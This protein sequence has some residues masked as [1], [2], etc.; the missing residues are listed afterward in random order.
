MRRILMNTIGMAVA[1]LVAATSM[2]KADVWWHVKDED[3]LLRWEYASLVL[4]TGC[5]NEMHSMQAIGRQSLCAAAG[6]AIG[7]AGGVII[8]SLLTP[9]EL[10]TTDSTMYYAIDHFNKAISGMVGTYIGL[11][12]GSFCGLRWAQQEAF[13]RVLHRFVIHWPEHRDNM[14]HELLATFDTLYRA[15]SHGS[16]DLIIEESGVALMHSVCSTIENNKALL[17]RKLQKS[18]NRSL[19]AMPA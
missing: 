3:A 18:L 6:S 17:E 19:R 9:S 4:V 5:D 13:K 16:L 8:G 1:I 2:L 7:A 10:S 14:P 11:V 15:Y 12:L